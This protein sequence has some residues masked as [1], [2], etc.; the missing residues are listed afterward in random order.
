[1]ATK[2][3][4]KISHKIIVDKYIERLLLDGKQP[5][6]VY[7]FAAGLEL[8]EDEFY[9]FFSSFDSLESGIWADFMQQTLTTLKKDKNFVKFNSREKLLAFFFTHLELLKKN[10]S[11]VTLRAKSLKK[12]AKTPFWMNKYKALYLEFASEL[13]A[14]GIENQEIKERPYLTDKYEKAFWLQLIFILDFWIN[15][16]SHQFE[17]T[18]AA[19][20]K[21][22]DLSFKILGESTLDSALDMAKFI[23]QT[24]S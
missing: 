20:E 24:R 18:D 23:W 17:N 14:E 11:Y 9:N 13:I 10:R 19:I 6:T 7:A 5:E 15:D 22:V 3:K 2:S 12:S 16:N 4:E 1:M 21:A 8:T